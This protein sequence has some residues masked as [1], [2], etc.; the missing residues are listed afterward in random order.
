MNTL[1][2]IC[3]NGINNNF[4][5][6]NIINKSQE[7]Q[8]IHQLT[9]YDKQYYNEE[10]YTELEIR[11]DQLDAMLN[12]TQDKSIALEIHAKNIQDV[13]MWSRDKFVVVLSLVDGDYEYDALIDNTYNDIYKTVGVLNP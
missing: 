2:L 6:C 8:E 9:A 13:F 7:L 10:V 12:I 5:V 3:T 1:Y 4:K 11:E